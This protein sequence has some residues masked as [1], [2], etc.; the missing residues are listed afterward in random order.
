MKFSKI[1]AVA[2]AFVVLVLVATPAPAQGWERGGY[3]KKQRKRYD[4]PQKGWHKGP[5]LAGNVGVARMC[6]DRNLVTGVEMGGCLDMILGLT[7]GWDIA[8]WIGP[9]LQINYTT[10]TAYVGNGGD[11]TGPY[12]ADTFPTENARLHALDLSLFARATLPYFTRAR[13]QWNNL[14]I[15][16]YTKLGATGYI[17]YVNSPTPA[18]RLGA[19]GL[20]PALGVGVEFYI[21]EGGFFAFDFTESLI[22]QKPFLRTIAGTA[23]QITEGGLKPQTKF[24][25]LFGWHF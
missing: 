19:V 23:T 7:L 18:N 11:A 5:Y 20:G 16:P 2:M 6:N 21:W 12:P 1:A 8:D 15:N 25:I 22:F 24:M 10:T 9:M 14:K 17:L 3:Y 13:W 4:F